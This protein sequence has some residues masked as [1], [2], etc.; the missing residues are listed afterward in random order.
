VVDMRGTGHPGPYKFWAG[1]EY[2]HKGEYSSPENHLLRMQRSLMWESNWEM[3]LP[4]L[5]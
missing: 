2:M 5:M 1:V 4:G 3:G